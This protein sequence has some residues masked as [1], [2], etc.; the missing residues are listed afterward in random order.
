MSLL[1][2]LT[3]YTSALPKLR[4]GR[5]NDGGYVVCALPDEYR[6]DAFISGGI[7]DDNSFELDVL[8]AHPHLAC[9]A[10]DPFQYPSVGQHERFRYHQ[11]RLPDMRH[12]DGCSNALVKIDIEGDEWPWLAGTL[13]VERMQIAQLV[14]ELHSPHLD[15]W[16]WAA[17]V[18]LAE[19]HA[20]VHFHANNWDGIVTLGDGSRCP[21]TC[22]TTWVRR[23]LAGALRLNAVP[24]PGPLDMPNRP[25]VA[26]HVIDWAPFV[27][28]GA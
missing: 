27:N 18:A 26:D 14:I 4:H 2:P 8:R 25:E 6:Y 13:R 19:T 5:S 16:S 1:D 9:D 11:E 10:Y 23:D 20:L 3:V 7:A 24:I 15:R 12:F 22:E 28:A 17:L 21:G